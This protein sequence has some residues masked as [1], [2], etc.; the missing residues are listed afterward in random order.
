[1][2]LPSNWTGKTGLILFKY[3][4]FFAI[5]ERMRDKIRIFWGKIIQI[6]ADITS[7]WASSCICCK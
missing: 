5:H 3:R 6:S 7:A 2:F 4:L 1:M